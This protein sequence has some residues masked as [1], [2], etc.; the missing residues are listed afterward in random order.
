VK[1]RADGAAAGGPDAPPAPCLADTALTPAPASGPRRP[2]P[3]EADHRPAGDPEGAWR[4]R[5]R[6]LAATYFE[7]VADGPEVLRAHDAAALLDVWC[8]AAEWL[9]MAP[10]AEVRAFGRRMAAAGEALARGDADRD[11]RAIP[12]GRMLGLQP[13]AGATAAHRIKLARR[14]A[15]L[16]ALRAATPAWRTL[17]PRRA[18]AAMAAAF[19]RY[20]AGGW[21]ADRRRQTAPAVEP[22]ATWWRVLRLSLAVAVPGV[23]RLAELLDP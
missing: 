21:R 14:D 1:G 22:A 10:D 18:A 7:R 6:W 8:A 5:G 4:R 13:A 16:R 2:A 9:E 3:G 19:R 17:P 20:E 23:D 12:L 15:M 11:G